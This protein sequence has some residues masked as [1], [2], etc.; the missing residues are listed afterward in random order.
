MMLVEGY[1]LTHI[2]YQG[3]GAIVYR[4][5]RTRD[6]V[7]VVCKL[8]GIE[9]PSP[10]DLS[11][12]RREYEL[13]AKL[14]GEGT[15][16]VY[17]L[18][19]VN[20]SLAIVMEDLGG[21]S[22]AS[23]LKKTDLGERF[24]IASQIADALARI[25]A[26]NVIH[27]DLNPS[28][29]IR[30]AQ[31]GTLKIIDFGIAAELSREATSFLDVGVMEGTPAYVSPEQTG[32]MNRP[33]DYRTDLYSLG[34][35]LYELF[36]GQV[37]FEGK[38]ALELVY[39]Q[40]AKLPP[41]PRAINPEIPE[42]TAA[43]ILKLL[44]KAPEDR[45][46]SAAGV[47]ADL[48]RCASDWSDKGRVDDFAIGQ[49]DWSSKFT[50]PNR[51]YGREREIAYLHDAFREICQGSS[52]LVLVAGAPGAGKT[53]L[54]QEIQKVLPGTQGFLISG[55]F[56]QLDRNIPY[57]ALFQAFR[58]LVDQVL[59]APSD[60]VTACKD[61]ILASLGANAG[62][63]VELV[64]KLERL[65]GPQDPPPPLEPVAAHNRLQLA[66]RAFIEAFV[67]NGHP[68]VLFLD[69]LQW[70]DPP[71]L[72]L[73]TFL[74]GGSGM[75]RL[76]LIGAYRDTEVHD[77][78]PMDF[79]LKGLDDR[80]PG[81]AG[82][83]FLEPLSSDVVNHLVADTLRCDAEATREVTA[84]VHGKTD[85]NPF[86]TNQMLASLHAQGAFS[87]DAAQNRWTWDLNQVANA[88]LS[89]NVVE[90]L[91]HELQS[92][93]APT[94]AILKIAA[95]IGSEFDLATVAAVYAEVDV[96]RGLWEAVAKEIV[97]P[98]HRHYR[99]LTVESSN[100][101]LAGV[102][103][104]FR[105]QH[106]RLLQ[107][108]QSMMSEEEKT[109]I[110]HR[111]GR[112]MQR[113]GRTGDF[114]FA[115]VNH[116]NIGRPHTTAR[117]ERLEL[118][119]LNALAGRKAMGSSAF[120]TA[121][122][123]LEIGRSLLSAEEW[124][125]EP[126]K[127]F[128]L[129]LQHAEAVFLAGDPQRAAQLTEALF[130]ICT[131]EM[132]R[133]W[134]AHLKSR[135]LES[136]GDLNGAIDEIRKALRP[137]GL[138]LPETEAE[139][140]QRVGMGLG[141]M[142]QGFAR[143]PIDTLVDLDRMRSPEKI[144]AMRL[145]AQAVPAAIQR[146]YALYMVATMMMMD[147]TLTHGLTPES[148]KCTAD[149]GIIY[150]AILGDYETGYRLGQAGFALIDKLKAHWQ[151]PA[152][153]FSFTYVSHM[154]KHYREGL[155]Y[156]EMS[157]RS[158]MEVG[159]MQHA[160]YARAHKVHMMMWV[161]ASLRDCRRETEAAISF[162][163][164]S[165]GL[166]QLMLANIVLHAVRKL[167][168]TPDEAEAADIAKVDGEIMATI[169]QTKNIVLLGR[170]S[171]YNAFL[172]YVLGE[173]DAAEQWNATA[174]SVS[175]AAGTDFPVA[176]HVLVQSLLAL[177]RLRK[178]EAA[179]DDRLAKVT[180]NLA[181]L[182]KYSN[183]CPENFAHKFYL[184]AAELSAFRGEPLEKTADLY[185]KALASIGKGEFP[186]MVALINER[187]A[188]FWIA[189]H[190]DT[191][192]KAFLREAHYHY[193][194]W[195]SQRK[196]AAMERQ[197][198]DY[199]ALRTDALS[200]MATRKPRRSHTAGHSMSN[201]DLDMTS[202]VKSTQAISSEIRTEKLLRTLLAT[203][204]EN[205]GAQSGCLLL[206]GGS[207]SRL[208]IAALKQADADT[209]E[210]VDA[211][212]YAG[213]GHVCSEI[214]EYVER[215]REAVVLDDA[216]MAGS[217]SG[218][219]YI[220]EH[221]IKSVL[222]M[223]VLQQNALKGMVYLE[224]S[225]SDH[226][227]TTERLS[228]LTILAAQAAISIENAR[229]YEDMESKVRERTKLLHQ[230]NERLKQLTLIDPL[231]RLNNRR[232]FHDHIAGVAASHMRKLVRASGAPEGGPKDDVMGVFLIDIDRFKEVNDT[233]GHAAGDT[234]LMAI[235]QVLKSLVRT[236]DFIVRWGGEEFL[237]ILNDTSPS[238]LD[239]FAR[240]ILRA[241]HE[242]P[243]ALSDGRAIYRTCSIGYAQ[244]PF[245]IGAPDFLSLEQT[246]RLSDVAMYVAKS[247]G[248][249]R[250]VHIALKDGVGAD[251]TLRDCL[252]A[253][254]QESALTT[255][256]I[257]LRHISATD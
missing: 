140:Q 16:R 10:S 3:G 239:R 234:V 105:F 120:K 92:L 235:S 197:Y 69:D 83:L 68:I 225:L 248:R 222:C 240:K 165:R 20:N 209:I 22:L 245:N 149:C 155:D 103:V 57:N 73:I 247:S 117:D 208:V 28:N 180:A 126:A 26:K 89:D 186:Q 198:S 251:D 183:N 47:L 75:S 74:L 194:Q 46:Q 231:T 136:Q 17:A 216:S 27:K 19:K 119:E 9:Y 32:R 79:F 112:A 178:G 144:M 108:V 162:L 5:T 64:P 142:Q 250:A 82:R 99:L 44:A 36:T 34:V 66:I 87:Y 77:G 23:S 182:E 193:G 61:A 38:D 78:H 81:S 135:I 40:I 157:Y 76:L 168:A 172:H 246:I 127:R 230:A 84:I 226:V 200:R 145:L 30:N 213:S 18:E 110:H 170:F 123:Y 52:K 132:E 59:R 203:I 48:K 12:F 91:V 43:L 24:K 189:R 179:T 65:L 184:L 124:Q 241:V 107:A 33:I 228:I 102:N 14:K 232:Y 220:R 202:I 39:A 252:L 204:I 167:E 41:D 21:E 238:F 72:E 192:A 173:L 201:A 141:G 15:V 139:I 56:N 219:A 187:Q 244:I 191:I 137:F 211:L 221:G 212:P 196:L 210:V 154:R 148:C 257:Q 122:D 218:S 70:S 85:G 45:Y 153:C 199:F 90:F 104:V 51:L 6:G 177:A 58:D 125:R 42:A 205:A 174:E 100:A 147:L 37:P 223:P 4:G 95:C 7:P 190:N 29:I 13:A 181:R 116:L 8:L 71:T 214:I 130:E 233:W 227:F 161:G 63:L 67:A 143:V 109:L 164:E 131:D 215:T 55:K 169:Q 97:I 151:K 53:S 159:D 80:S 176:D 1:A 160:A 50:L 106:D 256:C 96:T 25:H 113:T 133:A 134:A 163:Q 94:K 185:G 2:L 146:N 31:T 254:S 171:Q 93:S 255:D 152:V 207:S 150:S 35:T 98:L 175:F 114:I 236:D 138:Y 217:F 62:L 60:L 188:A 166:V 11:A 242:T 118:A 111:V 54:I 156:Y 128:S 243:I 253:L 229:L 158:G 129:S 195:G 49:C 206:T 101:N 115:L 237:V 249:D 86:F 121:A 88:E 224:N